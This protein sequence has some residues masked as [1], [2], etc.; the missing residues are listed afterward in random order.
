[1]KRPSRKI[2]KGGSESEK[3]GTAVKEDDV[4]FRAS[5]NH[6]AWRRKADRSI[7]LTKSRFEREQGSRGGF[8]T[9]WGVRRTDMVRENQISASPN[10]L[11]TVGKLDLTSTLRFLYIV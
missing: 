8:G 6:S 2:S 5:I 10:A 1:V 3:Y 9:T 4:H 11:A 7:T